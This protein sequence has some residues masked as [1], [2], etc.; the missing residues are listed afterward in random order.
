MV[1]ARIPYLISLYG[2]PFPEIRRTCGGGR[3]TDRIKKERLYFLDDDPD[4]VTGL[5]PVALGDV[6]V[7]PQA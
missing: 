5:E 3:T 6:D 1:Y 7:E 2:S 4:P